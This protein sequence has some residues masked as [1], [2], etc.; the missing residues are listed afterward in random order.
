MTDQHLFQR[1]FLTL[2]CLSCFLSGCARSTEPAPTP[3]P[4]PK[5]QKLGEFL[6]Q[7]DG[8]YAYSML[9]P[10]S[11]LAA[12]EGTGRVYYPNLQDNRMRLTLTAVNL[13]VYTARKNIRTTDVRWTLYRDHPSLEGWTDALVRTLYERDVVQ[14]EHSLDHA[15][16]YSVRT[17]AFGEHI[18]LVA[19]G[20]DQSTPFEIILSVG[21]EQAQM[22]EIWQS[23]LMDDFIAMVESVRAAP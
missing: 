4:T 3:I 5:S 11:W 13:K 1:W 2:L 17:A 21:G 14:L 7:Q 8:D 10:A 19:Y 22:E 12:D 23:G 20:I 6:W 15:R 16:I 18:R 9:R